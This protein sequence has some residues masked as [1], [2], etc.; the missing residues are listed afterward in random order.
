MCA[1]PASHTGY[2]AQPIEKRFLLRVDGQTKLH[3]VQKMPA[4]MGLW[5][6]AVAKRS[7]TRKMARCR[8]TACGWLRV[9]CDRT[10]ASSRQQGKVL[11][12]ER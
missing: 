5:S 12:G 3:S 2:Q 6:A 8:F 10:T 11:A 7:F 4:I 9:I 1:E